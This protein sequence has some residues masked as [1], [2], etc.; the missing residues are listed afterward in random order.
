M[1]SLPAALAP[2]ARYRQFILCKIVPAHP[3]A[4]K[5]PVDWRTLKVADAHDPAIWTGADEACTLAAVTGLEV[6]FVFTKDDPFWFL[7]VDECRRGNAWSET[8]QQLFAL[9]NGAAIEVSHSGAG[10]HFFGRGTV[11]PHSTRCG[12]LGLEF[13]TEKRFA[14]LTGTNAVGNADADLTEPIGRLVT[15]C[16]PPKPEVTPADW[17]TCP[18]PEWRGPTDDDDLIRRAMA[19]HGAASVF[20]G[21]ATFADLWNADAEALGRTYPDSKRAFDASA[22][23][24][25]LAQHLAYW[26]GKD[27]ERI[28]RLMRRSALVRDKWERADYLRQRTILGAVARCTKVCLDRPPAITP[29]TSCDV[30]L[31]QIR[32]PEE[33]TYLTPAEQI[34]LFAGCVYVVKQNR[35]L[36]PNGDLLSHDQF[37]AVYGGNIF[38][39]DSQ[40]SKTTRDAFAA[41]TETTAL[42]TPRADDVIFRPGTPTGALVADDGRTY[43]NMWV[44]PIIRR[45]LGVAE[46]IHRHFIILMPDP[47]DRLIWY[48]FIAALAQNPEKAFNYLLLVQGVEGNGKTIIAKL[49]QGLV[50][51]RYTYWAPGGKLNPQ[52]NAWMQFHVL[53][54][55]ED[56]NLPAQERAQMF[57]ILKPLIAGSGR[58]E[59]ERKGVDQATADICLKW[60]VNTNHKGGLPKSANDRRICPLYCA[61]QDKSHLVRDGLDHRYFADLI[62]AI[63]RGNEA[64]KFNN[65]M[66]EFKIPDEFNPALGIIA[67][68]TSF[69]SEAIRYGY[70]VIEEEILEAIAQEKP[71]FAGGWVSSMALDQL[72]IRLGRSGSISFARR[73]DILQA[74]GFVRHPG[75]PDGRAPTPVLPDAGKPRLYIRPDS[76]DVTLTGAAAAR[77]YARAQGISA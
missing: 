45:D 77:A 71:G 1:R 43:A 30:A 69:T 29:T 51:K 62:G 22:A 58:A 56:V 19:A 26:T 55:I 61:Q 64:A 39:L 34:Q 68:T 37:K 59:I 6:G 10:L 8:A 4:L 7:D 73:T 72:L 24:G 54:I 25:A 18:V 70:G 41:F 42:R 75:L 48:S 46:R 28:E 20:G 5:F 2:L 52:F 31:Q 60:Y 74:L 11:P 16:F 36:V 17:T 49:L 44:P 57:E 21:R 32:S 35:V 67:P 15:A 63:E 65:E 38:V 66:L 12:Q 76:P 33:S 27:C 50:G 3:K 14:V 40:N 9:L 53:A 13:Y 47:R 23:D